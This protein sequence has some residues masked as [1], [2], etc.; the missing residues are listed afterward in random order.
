MRKKSILLGLLTML[1]LS[2]CGCE[3]DKEDVTTG[4][5]TEI[6]TTENEVTMEVTTE[7]TEV[8]TEST[9]EVTEAIT[10][11]TESQDTQEGEETTQESYENSYYQILDSNYEIISAGKDNYE[12]VDGTNG[13][14]EV[15]MSGDENAIN[16]IGYTFYDVNGDGVAELIIGAIS[17][18]SDGKYY[19][20][21]IYS[22]YTHKD[23][24]HLLLEGWS[25]NRCF[26]L[27]DGT[28]YTEGSSGAMYSVFENYMLGPNETE[29]TYID[30]YFTK[31]KDET[32]EEYGFYHN[33]TGDWDI[34]VSEELGE[35]EYWNKS[36]EYSSRIRTLEFTPF[37]MYQY[38]GEH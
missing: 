29:L 32:F 15:V 27:D 13:I 26:L 38:T 17:E 6:V 24:P 3:N 28:F 33:T 9:T 23:T 34:T 16:N 5:S 19:G 8:T 25:R 1:I 10:E 35:D 36:A 31:E 12:Y 22:V 21:Y 18:E 4:T 14:G 37:S 2:L 30:Y 20:Q 7:A 11:S